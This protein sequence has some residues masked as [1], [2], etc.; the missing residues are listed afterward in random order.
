MSLTKTGMETADSGVIRTSRE[1]LACKASARVSSGS[2]RGRDA[3][4]AKRKTPLLNRI[5]QTRS[6]I[7]HKLVQCAARSAPGAVQVQLL[8]LG[9][10][11]DTSYN[12]YAARVYAVDFES[13]VRERESA[14]ASASASTPF[15]VAYL[16]WDLR[17]RGLLTALRGKG[18]DPQAPTVVLVECVLGYIDRESVDALLQELSS[19]ACAALLLYD[20]LLPKHSVGDGNGVG[21]GT[22]D[23][24]GFASMTLQKFATRGAPLLSCNSSPT[25]YA[26]TLRRVGWL[27]STAVSVNGAVCAFLSPEERTGNARAGAGAGGGSIN[28]DITYVEPFDEFASLA[29]LQNSYAVALA[30]NNSSWFG[31]LMQ[32]LTGWGRDTAIVKDTDTDTYVQAEDRWQA[33][34]VRAAMCE[35]RLRLCQ[36]Q[37][38]QETQVPKRESKD[39]YDSLFH[40]SIGS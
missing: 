15:R 8:L 4:S 31:G 30:S 11:L 21:D 12:A 1:A 3:D 26:S 14:S 24:D 32:A 27:H 34:Q 2:E 29:L 33:L 39:R 25:Q 6:N 23:G 9:C 22:G 28:R 36:R 10:G 16:G 35:L 19:L 18:F 37:R 13:V 7:M 5:Y 20:P 38:L 17:E 40:R